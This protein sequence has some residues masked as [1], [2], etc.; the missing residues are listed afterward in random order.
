MS[1]LPL[2]VSVILNTNHRE[3]TL[4]CLGSLMKSP[5]TNHQTIVLDNASSDGSVQAIS[6]AF[7]RAQIISLHKNLGYA[8]NNNVGIQAALDAGAEWI[9]VLNE[10]IILDPY[11]ISHLIEAGMQDNT[12]G[13]VGPLV[14]HYH[15]PRV[16]QSA[17]GAFDR[18]WLSSHYGQNEPDL[19]QFERVRE[20]EWVSGCAM[21]LRRSAIESSGVI[22]ERFFYYWEETE[23]CVRIRK[24]HWKIVFAPQAKIWHKG[25]QPNYQPSPNV[26]Y[27]ATR[28]RFLLLSS[29]Q[30]PWYAWLSAYF[31][32]LRTLL[33]WSIRPNWR[34]KGEHR[35][36]LWQGL[37]DFHRGRLGMRSTPE[38]RL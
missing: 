6:E 21:M 23:W 24:H 36:A 11:A 15:E 32:T 31:S 16:I 5:Y 28:N 1:S 34:Q 26:T 3:D 14:Y 4:A 35:D 33:A 38:T 17:G 13:V 18:N 10:D 25:V 30:A 29:H 37:V 2:V 20:V 12:I 8:G 27:Y 22:D 9:F 7:P 19:G